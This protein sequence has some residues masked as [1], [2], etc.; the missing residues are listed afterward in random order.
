[1]DN[2]AQISA[3][4]LIIMAAVLGVALILVNGLL[5]TG[6]EASKA[7]D[8]KTSALLEKINRIG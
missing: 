1:M 2:K 5:T 6:E 3:E 8:N 4:L 7:L